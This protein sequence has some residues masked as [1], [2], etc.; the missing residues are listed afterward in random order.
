M[1]TTKTETGSYIQATELCP[2]ITS[3]CVSREG[4]TTVRFTGR[5]SDKH[6]CGAK[7]RNSTG[8]SC[9]CSCGGHNHGKDRW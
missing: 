1:M 9:T 2:G 3:F 7:C 4:M 8:P 5:V 6:T